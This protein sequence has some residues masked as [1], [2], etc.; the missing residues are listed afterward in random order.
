MARPK[1]IGLSMFPF[2][3][4]FFNDDKIVAVAGEFGTKGE[5]TV[6]KLL[7]AIYRQGY[8]LVWN[9]PARIRLANELQGVSRELLEQIVLRLVKWGFFNRVIFESSNVLTSRG[10]QKRYFRETKRRVT[11]GDNLPYLLVA[12]PNVDIPVPVE[13]T[14]KPT[15]AVA[16][17]APYAPRVAIPEIVPFEKVIETMRQDTIWLEPVC[18]RYSLT[19]EQFDAKVTE[20]VEHCKCMS[21]V[22][23]ID[24][25]KE[26]KRYFCNWLRI[27]SNQPK[28]TLTPPPAPPRS[29]DYGG[30]FGGK[31]V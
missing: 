14:P 16:P 31:D 21:K 19:T 22:D 9:E 29:A 27:Q 18:M 3:V 17:P 28:Q 10:I 23:E 7:C 20:F 12:L 13:K 25:V 6:V 1:K 30:G 11:D 24:T 26:G 15:V 8:Y 2:S 5:I 4:D